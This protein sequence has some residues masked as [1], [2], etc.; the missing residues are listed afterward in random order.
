MRFPQIRS[1]FGVTP[2]NPDRDPERARAIYEHYQDQMGAQ[3]LPD[4]SLPWNVPF[5]PGVAAQ[6]EFDDML[7]RRIV[8]PLAQAGYEDLG[9]GLAAVP[10]AAHSMIVPQT[11][12]DLAGT[13]I[14]LPG[15]A[16]AMKKGKF[17]KIRNAM[18]AEDPEN[19]AEIIHKKALVPEE[20]KPT[21]EGPKAEVR[22]ID[23]K[24]ML[25]KA[26]ARN[27]REA[28]E[29]AEAPI[30][31]GIKKKYGI[32]S[33]NW[34][35]LDDEADPEFGT[36]DLSGKEGDVIEITDGEQTIQVLNDEYLDLMGLSGGIG[37]DETPF[38]QKM[39]KKSKGKPKPEQPIGDQT[40]PEIEER[41][42]RIKASLSKIDELMEKLKKGE[43]VKTPL[44]VVEP[45]K[46]PKGE[47]EASLSPPPDRFAGIKS[48]LDVIPSRVDERGQAFGDVGSYDFRPNDE[49]MMQFE[50]I[51]KRNYVESE[52]GPTVTDLRPPATPGLLQEI[53]YQKPKQFLH[54]LELE[55]ILRSEGPV[56]DA[57]ALQNK[58]YPPKSEKFGQ[59]KEQ[60]TEKSL[61]A[62]PTRPR[63]R[64]IKVGDG[65]DVTDAFG[66]KENLAG[67]SAEE[68]Q[69][70]VDATGKRYKVIEDKYIP[71]GQ[72]NTQGKY[73]VTDWAGNE[74]RELGT[75]DS[76]EDAHDEL[77]EW[78]RSKGVDEADLDL[79]VGEF[80]VRRRKK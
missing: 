27:A 70:I 71:S 57:K 49:M 17:R 52:L 36:S 25:R 73:Y 66:S 74:I 35:A 1:T 40:S 64:V 47:P 6:R 38:A 76:M 18:K 79:E 75:Y 46:P 19:F 33:E 22:A 80:D 42:Q 3:P 78:L 37:L 13:I 26:D 59:I 63:L 15:V 28:R 60:I 10:S 11:E 45:P 21:V 7:Q 62:E 56:V 61:K 31:E 39:M 65:K 51:Q 41:V 50:P 32:E 29:A 9:A 58:M 34:N 77:V 20:Y 14:P 48:Q 30:R 43:P 54:D 68:L 53:M 67:M 4:E 72:K 23:E 69:K 12:M 2:Y 44:K 24:E 16:K 5:E 55:Q 8:D